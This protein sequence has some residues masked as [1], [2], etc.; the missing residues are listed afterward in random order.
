MRTLLLALTFLLLAISAIADTIT[1]RSDSWPPY[2]DDPKDPK[3]GYMIEV[4]KAIYEPLGHKIDYQLMSWDESLENVAK[5]KFNAVVGAAK[6]DAENFVFPE[7]TFGGSKNTFFVLKTNKWVY[8]DSESIKQVK[9]GVIEDYSYSE[10]IDDYI[11]EN[12]KNGKVVFTRGEEAL[13]L[14]INR[15]Q[16]GKVDAV[17]ED[18]SVMIFALMK[19]KIPPSE[20]KAVGTPNDTQNIYVAFS[21]ALPNSKKYAQQFDEGIRKLRSSGKLKQIMSRYNLSDWR[22]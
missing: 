20:I 22:K 4:M 16:T 19:M 9:L 7:E 11:K 2:N 5:G 1:I 21:P 12:K 13:Q 8:T 15:L 17:V 18:A 14:L 3:A 10:V 6:E